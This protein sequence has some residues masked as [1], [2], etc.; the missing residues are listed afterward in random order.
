MLRNAAV[1]GVQIYVVV[2][3]LL[4]VILAKVHTVFYQSKSE[5][6]LDFEQ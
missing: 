3:T 2:G 5:V 4:E 1:L 6:L